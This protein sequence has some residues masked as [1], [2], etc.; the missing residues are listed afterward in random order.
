MGAGIRGIS[1]S[2]CLPHICSKTGGIDMEQRNYV[3]VILYAFC[4]SYST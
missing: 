1:K 4:L 3:T 2:Q